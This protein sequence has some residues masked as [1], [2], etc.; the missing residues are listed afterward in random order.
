ME[1]SNYGSI[2]TALHDCTFLAWF[3]LQCM[4]SAVVSFKRYDGYKLLNM[5]K[6]RV[7]T[8]RRRVDNQQ[9]WIQSKC[10]SIPP[11]PN[12]IQY[13]HTRHVPDVLA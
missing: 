10:F 9:G 11:L 2:Y 1:A 13:T 3:L 4:F 8:E 5:A 7:Y 6:P 12:H